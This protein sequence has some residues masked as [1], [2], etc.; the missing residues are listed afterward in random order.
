MEQTQDKKWQ[1]IYRYTFPNGKMYIGKTSTTLKD[2]QKSGWIGYEECP[3]VFNA[4]NYYKPENIKQEILIEGMMTD[5]QINDLERYYI[6]LY[7]TNCN[8][9]RNPEYGYNL[10]DGGDGVSGPRLCCRGANHHNSKSVYCIELDKYYDNAI[11][12]SNETGID[13]Y[14]IRACC[15][16][17]HI[18][19]KVD[20][21]INSG[22][23][24]LWTEDVCDEKIQEA[25]SKDPCQH[26]YTPVYCIEL[27][28]YYRSIRDA[29]L[30]LD[31]VGI[32]NVINDKAHTAGKHPITKEPLH[33]L[34]ASE[35]NEE[36]I[37]KALFVPERI[38]KGTEVYCIELDMAF[39][40][41]SV[42]CKALGISNKTMSKCLNGEMDY[43]GLNPYDGSKLHWKLLSDCENLC[44]IEVLHE[45]NIDKFERKIYCIELDMSFDGSRDAAA[46]VHTSR[47]TLR[48][49]LNGIREDAGFHPDTGEPLHWKYIYNKSYKKAE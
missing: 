9:Y 12:A 36:N 11:I 7:K 1:A 37:Q 25:L 38:Y 19:C 28:Q 4:I 21:K 26:L 48:E 47:S 13:P 10:T 6:A 33:W 46:Y 18:V 32:T 2:R 30:K 27:G 43:A 3:A 40:S 35:V 45:L 31:I 16:G 29:E 23:H 20:G 49:C 41:I 22:W 42:P 44:D 24:W 14:A 39:V 8:R 34:L 17:E 5:N 15:R